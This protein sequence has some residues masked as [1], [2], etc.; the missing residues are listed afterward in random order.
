[1]T[2]LLQVRD[3]TKHYRPGGRRGEIVRA[4]DG[5]SFDVAKGSTMAIVGESG[6]GKST[7]G[8]AI[9]R[10]IE[11]TSGQVEFDGTDLLAL[12]PN[13]LRRFRSRMQIVFQDTY[14]SLDPRWTVGRLLGEPLTLHTDLGKAGIRSRVG[15][16][17]ETVGLPAAFAQRYPHEFSGGQR[18]RIGIARA[19]MLRPELVVCD[20]P[21]SALDV[22]VQAQVL[23]LMKDLQQEF[24]LTY[25][26]ISHD[27]SV[28]EFMAEDIIVMNKGTVVEKGVSDEV[29]Q[30]PQHPYTKALLAA[31]PVPD[32]SVY[33]D[34]SARRQVIREGLQTAADGRP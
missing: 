5:I 12:D 15:E 9:L 13:E 4:V 32:P 34:R 30:D 33:E 10:L 28:V 20:E 16:M 8:R 7:A 17:L 11:P 23:N 1:M 25:V 24:G 18:Q 29:L 2:T 21:V 27:L 14:A 6:S 31:V 22:S 3:L 26:F 19:L